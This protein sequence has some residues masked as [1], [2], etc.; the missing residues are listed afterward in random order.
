[1][2]IDKYLSKL[3]LD[4]KARNQKF[5]QIKC[6]VCETNAKSHKARGYI[7]INGDEPY[8]NCF[9]DCGGSSFYNF[10]KEQNEALAKE[11]YK[12]IK[13]KDRK[14]TFDYD[15]RDEV[16]GKTTVSE[17]LKKMET[18]NNPLGLIVK[19]F[20]KAYYTYTKDNEQTTYEKELSPLSDEAKEY[21]YSRGFKDEDIKDFKFVE[22]QQ[23]IVIPCWF[24]RSKN[25]VYGMQ[26][27]RITDKIFHNQF[28]DTNPKVIGLMDIL[29][30]PKGTKIYTFESFFDMISTNIENTLAVL[31]GKLT[32][33]LLALL[34][35]YE[36]IHCG[37]ADPAGYINSSKLSA[38]G[39]KVLVH[40]L[41]MEN[42]KDFNKLLELGQS[43]E[44]ITDY[45]MKNIRSP[46]RATIELRR[47]V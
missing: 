15:K 10:L 29:R 11:Y 31:G 47:R 9:N 24:D 46:K 45:I 19:E 22:E 37:D 13:L 25:L 30:L 32:S 3:N 41:M 27:R 44:A 35:D 16:F 1:M 26:M 17:V 5:I 40:E 4:I 21:L 2:N 7:M 36:I 6:P 23:D 20:D 38:K 18:E 12:D 39:H 28:F 14:H 34:K 42:F 8:Y 33:E 43:K